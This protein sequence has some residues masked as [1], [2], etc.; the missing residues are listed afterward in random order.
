VD[1]D[2]LE[3]ERRRIFA[4]TWQLVAH[5]GQL[6]ERG[7][8]L[9]LEVA[10][11]PLVLV[12]DRD[13]LRGFYNVCRHRAG[14]VAVGCGRRQTLQCAYHGWTYGLDGRL[15]RAPEMEDTPGFRPEEVALAPVR[16]EA[17][18]PLL[19]VNLDQHAP[20]LREA[21]EDLP[22]RAA[23]F[24]IEGMAHTGRREYEVACNWKVYVDNYLE[25]YH[26]PVV[27]PGLLREL[28]YDRYRVETRGSYS[29]QHAPLR[30]LETARS[31][32]NYYPADDDDQADYY[33]LF[34]NLML[35]LYQGQL[36]TNAVVPAGVD[37]T[38]VVFDWFAPAP[39]DPGLQ[40]RLGQ[41]AAFSD[42]VQEED[43]R[44]CEAVQR[45]LASAAAVPGRY[46]VRRENGVH[47]FHGLLRRH[48]GGEALS[49][50][51]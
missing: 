41:L 48:L 33:W 22:E 14:P 38:V 30:P 47:H 37:R 21:L 4:R 11:E 2:L 3:L 45:N 8:F 32:R 16:V 12:R 46:C 28:D 7:A 35:N 27:H 20:P 51:E 39:A 44:I 50:P 26:I 13:A 10:G 6:A 34:P 49:E 9:C 17:W 15:R 31:E 24:G 43:R 1:P 18:G 19:F 42:E 36:Q 25:G 23:R 29:R 5:A 40:A